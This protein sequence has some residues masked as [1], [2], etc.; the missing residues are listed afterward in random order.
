VCH[1]GTRKINVL[2]ETTSSMGMNVGVWE[3][4][5][6]ENGGSKIK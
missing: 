5:Y 4:V 2:M 1:H 3:E 6:D